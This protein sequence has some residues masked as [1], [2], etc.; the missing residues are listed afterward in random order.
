MTGLLDLPDVLQ[1]LF[2]SIHAKH[3]KA[4]GAEERAKRSLDRVSRVT[5][6][7]SEQALKVQYNDG[8]WW[9]Y[10]ADGEWY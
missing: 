3:L 4:M 8:E 1:N 6:D 9:W 10:G 7:K 2:H 5:W